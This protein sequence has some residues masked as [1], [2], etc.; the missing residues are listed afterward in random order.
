MKRVYIK[1]TLRKMLEIINKLKRV[2]K[3]IFLLN[4]IQKKL[5]MITFL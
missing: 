4:K 5:P 3:N 1:I 2:S